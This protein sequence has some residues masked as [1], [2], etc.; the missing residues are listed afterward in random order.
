[1]ITWMCVRE[2]AS[3]SDQDLAVVGVDGPGFRGNIL[4]VG[5]LVTRWAMMHDDEPNSQ[6]F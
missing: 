4:L 3:N 1:M 2:G 6:H 5:A